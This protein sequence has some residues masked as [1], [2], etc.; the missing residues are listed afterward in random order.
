MVEEHFKKSICQSFKAV[1][2]SKFLV[3]TKYSLPSPCIKCSLAIYFDM[4]LDYSIMNC[5]ASISR[6]FDLLTVE[7][8][9]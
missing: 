7:C 5:S 6:H 8:M 9:L 3:C 2:Y 1:I 4:K